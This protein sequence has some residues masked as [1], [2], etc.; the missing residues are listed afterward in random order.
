MKFNGYKIEITIEKHI[1]SLNNSGFGLSKMIP[2]NTE[3]I[4]FYG[5]S[6]GKMSPPK[7]NKLDDIFLL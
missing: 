6:F 1:F 3:Y 2:S 4:T 7:K 5:Q